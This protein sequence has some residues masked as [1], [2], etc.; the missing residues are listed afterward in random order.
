MFNV[1]KITMATVLLASTTLPFCVQAD[2]DDAIKVALW[3]DNFYADNSD[4]KAAQ[5]A[6]TIDSMNKHHVD[7][8]IFAGDTKNGHT[9]CTDEA[10]TTDVARI[11]DSLKAPTMYTVGDNEWTDCHRANNGAFDPLERLALLRSFFFNKDTS[12]G[13]KPIPVVRQGELGE[14]YSENSRFVKDNVEFVALH[15]PGSNNNLVASE[16]D[17][18][19]KTGR[20][21]RV[22]DSV[23][24]VPLEECAAATAE[25][26]AR[27]VK[28]LE[29]LQ[30][31]F[32]EARDK[33]YA[34]ILIAVQADVYTSTELSDGGFQEVFLPGLHPAT[35]G[36]ADFFHTLMAET[37]NYTG[38]VLLVHGDSHYFRLDK[39]MVDADG[40]AIPN[41]TR[42]EVFGEADNSWV[43]MTVDPKSENVFEFKPVVLKK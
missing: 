7:F 2:D 1:S 40:R 28:N 30:A 9:L 18:T 10:I 15:I 22:W 20:P 35:N 19:K 32:Q 33:N 12:Q 41:F 38:Q 43:E 21:G 11:F 29:W 27:N 31:A 17:C 5:I 8:T 16:K 4:V 25:Y 24:N 6:Q 39:A 36:Y 3:G 26:K 42:V 37:L 23:N 13:T 14:A 34:G